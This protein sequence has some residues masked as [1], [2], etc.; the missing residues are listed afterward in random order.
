MNK[1]FNFLFKNNPV[2]G[3]LLGMCSTL[4]VSTTFENSY[5]MGLTVFFVLLITSLIV[6]L[7]S[8]FV[9]DE[10]RIPTYIIIIATIVSII[11]GLLLKYS[12]PVYKALGIYLPLVTVNCIIMGK[13]LE[14]SKNKNI[15]SNIVDSIQTG[16]GY[17]VAISIFG[18]VR[19]I[20]GN[21]TITIMN[22][23]T[24]LTGYKMIYEI[25]PKNNLL[26]NSIFIGA[27]GAFL[28][29]AFIIA[30][31]NMKKDREEKI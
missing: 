10:I 25:L 21:N 1:I 29:L 26:P 6:S 31:I 14:Y 4:A 27:S 19:E 7:I 18:L 3:M 16:S 12:L 23:L 13:S 20:L 9:K 8:R 30:T 2:F 24:S 28:L 15:K 5:I 22:N 17:L 11:E